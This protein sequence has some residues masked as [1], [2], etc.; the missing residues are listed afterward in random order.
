MN[1]ANQLDRYSKLLTDVALNL[2]K[3]QPVLIEAEITHR[4]LVTRVV[5]SAYRNGSPLVE[6]RYTDPIVQNL[7]AKLSREENLATQRPGRVADYD[8]I[9]DVEGARLLLCGSEFTDI[10][11]D[12]DP[13]RT[14]KLDMTR[15]EEMFKYYKEALPNN[16]VHWTIAPYAT[17]SWAKKVYPELDPIV[18]KIKLWKDFFTFLRLDQEDY[19]DFWPKQ[20]SRL[21][22]RCSKLNALEI[23]TLHFTG[24]NINF[25]VGISNKAR[26]ASAGSIS[27]RGHVFFANIP[28]EEC[29]TTPDYRFT[30]GYLK[31]SRPVEL[32]GKIVKGLFLKFKN[33]EVVEYKADENEA[34]VKSFLEMDPN[35]R[36]LGEV[37]LVGIDSPIFR[38]NRIY[39]ETLLDENAACHIAL[40]AGFSDLI[41]GS[42]GLDETAL[43]NLGVN[44][45]T[46]HKDIMIS[47]ES[48]SVVAT[49]YSGRTIPI[50]TN[51]KFEDDFL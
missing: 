38:A 10:S 35:T 36:F 17:E 19:L 32:G 12:L 25:F 45:A 28:T 8:H 22:E 3:D 16:L 37:A 20:K 7:R 13:A 39:Y 15:R 24:P 33:G 1:I 46:Q 29:F 6:V 31:A 9:S 40:G 26:F 23:K 44:S 4:D 11:E 27:R 41:K 21:D 49:T 42:A 47:D 48:V 50:I 51:G 14:S 43:R 18:A 5:E 2:Q 34:A 30:E